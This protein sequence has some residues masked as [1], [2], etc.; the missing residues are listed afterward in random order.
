MLAVIG[1]GSNQGDRLALLRSA[2]A[3][4][5]D[6]RLPGT[7]VTAVSRVYETRPIGPSKDPYLNAAVAVETSLAPEDLLGGLK[8]IEAEH[9][10]V[11][12]ERWGARTLDLDFLLLRR[13]GAWVKSET[14]SLTLPHP[15]VFVRDFV[16]RPLLD[17][18][19]GLTVGGERIASRLAALPA[20]DHT[21]LRVLDAD[22]LSG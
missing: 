8:R 7:R 10:R 18:D 15:E 13:D 9:G 21:V 20:A 6:G 4:L 2:V 17:L 5:S 16:M 3:A 14:A 11:R 1:L 19:P 22:L 12:D